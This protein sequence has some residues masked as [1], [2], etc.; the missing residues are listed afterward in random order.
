MST[1]EEVAAAGKSLTGRYLARMLKETREHSGAAGG[2]AS[3]SSVDN[4]RRFG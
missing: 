4:S 1:P 3:R 2:Q